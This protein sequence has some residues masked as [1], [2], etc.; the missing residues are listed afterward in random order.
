MVM[1]R[2]TVFTTLICI[3]VHKIS[4]FDK[5]YVPFSDSH[6]ELIAQKG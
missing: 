5:C 6:L 4:Q 3:D 1:A 2:L